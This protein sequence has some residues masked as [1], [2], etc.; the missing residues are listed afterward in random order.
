M[1][2]HLS[3]EL[4]QALA[5]IGRQVDDLIV[6]DLKT[7]ALALNAEREGLCRSATQ[8]LRQMHEERSAA[9]ACFTQLMLCAHPDL[10]LST[11]NYFDAVA[12]IKEMRHDR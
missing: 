4:T 11:P 3:N 5:D 1:N 12:R 6:P 2:E 7:L 9:I 8:L 10:A